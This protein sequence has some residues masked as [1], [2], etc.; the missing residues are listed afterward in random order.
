ML[1]QKHFSC[2]VFIKDNLRVVILPY[3]TLYRQIVCFSLNCCGS[4]VINGTDGAREE[5]R[6]KYNVNAL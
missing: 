5:L 2:L 1:Q 4:S 6:N 3:E